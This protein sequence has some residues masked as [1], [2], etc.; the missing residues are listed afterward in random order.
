[1]IVRER[2]SGLKLFFLLRGSILKQ[3]RWALLANVLVALLVTWTHGAPLFH[4]KIIVTTIPFTLIGIALSI[5]LSFRNSACYERW[6]E[7]RKL[8]GDLL[9]RGRNLARQMLSLVDLP[10]PPASARDLEDVRVR[11]VLRA[12]AFCQA[13][14]QQLRGAPDAREGLQPLLRPAD[15]QALA[16][17]R[18]VAAALMMQMGTDLNDCRR[19]GQ[20]DSVRAASIDATLSALTASAAGCERIKSSPLPFSYTLLLHRTAYLFCF[21]LPFGLVDSIGFMTPFV[22]GIVAYTFFGLDALGD[23]I[24]EPFGTEANDLPLEA[25]CRSIEIDLRQA[26]GETELPAPLQPVDFVLM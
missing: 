15:W 14:K 17:Q 21:I 9:L 23:E 26:L 5:F 3:I 7:A 4:Q 18:N 1:M 13:L 25:I 20:L 24:E 6:W 2:P 10:A 16:G 8:W 22:V 19:A 11:M 12:V